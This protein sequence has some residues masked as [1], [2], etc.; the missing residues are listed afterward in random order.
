MATL[1]ILHS[2]TAATLQQILSLMSQHD[3]LL[4]LGDA[5]YL[6]ND[7]ALPSGF[8][9]RSTDLQLRGIPA[10]DHANPISD[11]QWIEQTLISDKSLSWF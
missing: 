5:C 10:P 11:E 6:A 9:L 4:L 1:H 3:S 8:M 7:P 2:A